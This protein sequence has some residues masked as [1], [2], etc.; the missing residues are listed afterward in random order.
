MSQNENFIEQLIIKAIPTIDDEGLDL[1][2]EDIK[3][4]LEERIMTHFMKTLTDEQLLAYM[5]LIKSNAKEKEI[6]DYL[7]K[8]IPSY[9]NFIEKIYIDF[10]KT[11]LEE[12]KN[13][14]QE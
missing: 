1:M 3:P 4:V 2:I 10:E 5:K 14:K 6:Y 8:V 9:D 12:F 7:N 13:F 11:Y